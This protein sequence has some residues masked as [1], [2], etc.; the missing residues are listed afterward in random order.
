MRTELLLDAIADQLETVVG[1]DELTQ[2]ILFSAQRYGIAP[3]DFIQQLTQ[4]NQLGAVYADV[5]R[6]KALGD[7]IRKFSVTDSDGN[8]IDLA[9]FYGED[10]VDDSAAADDAA[11]DTESSDADNTDAKSADAK[12]DDA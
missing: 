1:Q 7:V 11:G 10:E 9:E 12:G 4:A 6:N 3:Q 2:Q 5:R 8:S